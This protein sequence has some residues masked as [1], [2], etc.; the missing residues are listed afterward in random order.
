M[1]PLPGFG[2]AQ[3]LFVAIKCLV[4]LPLVVTGPQPPA[5]EYHGSHFL[6]GYGRPSLP[7]LA[8]GSPDPRYLTIGRHR[9]M[10]TVRLRGS[11]TVRE[12]TGAR[13]AVRCDR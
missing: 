10:S 11:A 2:L 7:S 4:D 6:G 8:E 13:K 5:A 12:S 9:P 1:V 3:L